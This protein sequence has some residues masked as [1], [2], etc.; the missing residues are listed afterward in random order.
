MTA[1]ALAGSGRRRVPA[2]TRT[3]QPT[4]RCAARAVLRRHPGR[5]GDR[6]WPAPLLGRHRSNVPLRQG[7]PHLAGLGHAIVDLGDDA[8][9][10]GRPHP[11]I[12]PTLRLEL[13]AQQA[14][15]PDVA[16][17]LLDVV[18]GLAADPDPAGRL[19]PAIAEALIDRRG[20]GPVAGGGR[21]AVRDGRRPAGPARP[22]RRRWPA[23]ARGVRLECRRRP[24]RRRARGRRSQTCTGRSRMATLRRRPAG[25]R[26]APAQP[27]RRHDAP[28][29]LAGPREVI[30]A[31]IDL[32]ADAL[33]AQAVDVVTVDYRPTAVRHRRRRSGSRCAAHRAGRPSPG[34]G[35]RRGRPA[36]AGRPRDARRRQ[37]GQRG[38]GAAAGRV[39][40]RRPADRVRRASGPLRGALIGA[41]IFEGLAADEAGGDRA[42]G[43]PGRGSRSVPATIGMPSGR[44]PA[45]SRRPCGCSNWPT[46]RPARARSAR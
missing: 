18:L 24:G 46:R 20:R 23:P 5:R 33:R 30:C 31:G 21:R 2:A 38:A 9:T 11:M 41:M 32:L 28:D 12:D 42:T 8:F 16:V 26:R 36:D 25:S 7:L 4:A 44:W 13:L 10:V 37:A 45:S 34:R 6:W 22:R 29:L 14:A 40:P 35:E 19:A 15:D 43:M 1:P 27:G 39:L 17:L 3:G